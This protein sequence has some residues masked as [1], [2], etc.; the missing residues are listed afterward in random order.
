M[1]ADSADNTFMIP[2]EMWREVFING[3]EPDLVQVPTTSFPQTHGPMGP[4]VSK[5][6][7]GHIVGVPVP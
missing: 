3:G 2:F 6:L 4:W 1:A 5:L 7:P